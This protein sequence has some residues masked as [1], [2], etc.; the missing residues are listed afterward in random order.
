MAATA[1]IIDR[2]LA[3]AV[4]APSPCNTQPW[5]FRVRGDRIDLYLDRGRVLPVAD[6]D[7]REALLACGA[8]LCNLRVSLRGQDR[9]ALVDLLPDS[10]RPDLLASVRLGGERTA[11]STE[12]KLAEA[13][14][15]R[16]TNR[17]P[18]LDRAVPLTARGKLASAARVEGAKLEFIEA[19]ARYDRIARLVR[20]ADHIQRT[21]PAYAEE[22]SAWTSGTESRQ[23]GVPASAEGPTPQQD[24][25]LALRSYHAHDG[26]PARPFEQQPLLV[27]A[28]TSVAGVRSTLRAGAGI[29]RALLT[30]T[31]LGLVA[32]FVSQPF[33]VPR[34]RAELAELFASDGELHTLLR[35]GYGYP[36]GPTPR[37]PPAAVSADEHE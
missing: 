6:P 20:R 25:V 4:L 32:S 26:L 31:Q 15:R 19:S 34:T 5:W 12:Y 1:Q 35:I 13:I 33:E 37:R 7:A 22:I 27:A 29:Q 23:D 14:S 8:A 3:D 16:H 2:A 11:T 24:G 18:F 30:A 17:H 36:L 28:L 21:E 10:E 9:L